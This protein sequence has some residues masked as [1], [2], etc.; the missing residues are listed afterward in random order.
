MSTPPPLTLDE[1]WWDLI[2]CETCGDWY[3]DAC[4]NCSRKAVKRGTHVW[5]EL[6]NKF[7]KKTTDNPGDIC[8]DCLWDEEYGYLKKRRKLVHRYFTDGHTP[9]SS[10]SE[11]ECDT[12]LGA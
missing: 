1:T 6:H 3:Q 7:F 10:E 2:K 12:A 8:E 4:E 11:T 9:I 5:C